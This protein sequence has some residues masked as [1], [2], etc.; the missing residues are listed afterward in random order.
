MN[1][2]EF[3]IETRGRSVS[4]T[5][6]ACGSTDV[7]QKL[8]MNS[9]EVFG[10]RVEYNAWINTCKVCKTQGD[11]LH[12]NDAVITEALRNLKKDL[13]EEHLCYL[14]GLHWAEH[15]LE[16]VLGLNL[17]SLVDEDCLDLAC[18]LLEVLV[19]S[20][21]LDRNCKEQ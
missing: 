18:A 6:P 2:S 19:K 9:F 5:C 13:V 3:N 15:D 20:D 7:V 1:E 12:L 4:T 17:G 11:F 8:T 10:K 21:Y 14:E 16:R